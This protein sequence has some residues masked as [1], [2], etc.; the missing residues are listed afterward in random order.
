MKKFW[1]NIIQ[2]IMLPSPLCE[3][4]WFKVLLC[5]SP[6][7][8]LRLTYEVDSSH[9]LGRKLLNKKKCQY[10]ESYRII[11]SLWAN[12][13]L[14]NIHISRYDEL[15]LHWNRNLPPNHTKFNN[16]CFSLDHFLLQKPLQNILKGHLLTLDGYCYLFIDSS[17]RRWV[18]HIVN[19]FNRGLRALVVGPRML[20]SQQSLWN[21]DLRRFVE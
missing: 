16:I 5:R 4:A 2:R 13:S 14:L 12:L 11:M 6:K 7:T 9:F 20:Q 21:C 1:L 10:H 15:K 17:E 8:S 18:P 3:I 19:I